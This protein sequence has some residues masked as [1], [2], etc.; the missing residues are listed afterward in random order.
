MNTNFHFDGHGLNDSN[1]TR[2][3]TFAKKHADDGGGYVMDRESMELMA[4]FIVHACNAHY[5]LVA[6]LDGAAEFLA[7]VLKKDG[8][9][10]DTAMAALALIDR[11]DSAIVKAKGRV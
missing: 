8:F 1:G 11:A 2:V 4:N 7:G 9:P 3:L 10:H 5:E 6:A